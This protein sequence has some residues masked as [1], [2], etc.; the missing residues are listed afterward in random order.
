MIAYLQSG[1]IPKVIEVI[2]KLILLMEQT[3]RQRD[4]FGMF[5]IP[6]SYA[7]ALLGASLGFKGNFNEGRIYLEK[8]RIVANETGNLWTLGLTENL[9]GR[10][11]SLKGDGEK[12]L[13]HYQ[14]A[15]QYFEEAEFPYILGQ[16][17]SGL[18]HGYHLV[19]DLDTA[20]EHCL[21]GLEIQENSEV[22]MFLSLSYRYSAMIECDSGNLQKAQGLAE[23]ALELSQNQRERTN[24]ALSSYILGTILTK[25]NPENINQAENLILKGIDIV[26]EMDLKWFI[27]LGYLRLGESYVNAGQKDKAIDHLYT[28]EKMFQKMGVDYYIAKIHTIYTELYKKEGDKSKA[29]ENLE[30]AIEIFKECGAD[31]WV[32]KYQRD[33]ATLS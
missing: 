23:K 4:N 3:Q 18:G 21:N 28:A 26:Q 19:G 1:Q 32:E 16:S 15:L 25:I 14:K 27:A 17:R 8:S 12:V 11:W 10:Y 13:K 9:Y 2:S 29:R 22:L 30:K 24:E 20:R 33:L 5:Y 7:C 31:G 6:Y